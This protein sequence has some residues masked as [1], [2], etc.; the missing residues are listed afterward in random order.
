MLNKIF[1]LTILGFVILTALS[2]V[3]CEKEKE[4]IGVIIVK[5]VDG[6]VFPNATVTLHQDGL[7]SQQGQAVSNDIRSS[8]ETD[9]NGRAQFVYENEAVLNVEVVATEANNQLTGASI[10]R[11]L[12]G[13]TVIIDVE[14]N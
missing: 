5:K 2:I 13:K 9:E 11:L 6:S 7:I 8:A 12:R 10:I 3:S 4:T 1:K 14:I